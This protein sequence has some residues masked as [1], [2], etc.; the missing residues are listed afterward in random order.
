MLY[1]RTQLGTQCYSEFF[2]SFLISNFSHFPNLPTSLLSQRGRK[3]K[4]SVW[5]SY[6]LLNT[7]LLKLPGGQLDNLVNY[8]TSCAKTTGLL[9][10]PNTN[11]FSSSCLFSQFCSSAAGRQ[12]QQSAWTSR[13]LTAE[14][15]PVAGRCSVLPTSEQGTGIWELTVVWFECGLRLTLFFLQYPG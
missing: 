3:K 6:L 13:A 7:L 8:L 15:G 9:S 2:Y 4:R 14:Q 1:C 5:F 11:P 10:F 12:G